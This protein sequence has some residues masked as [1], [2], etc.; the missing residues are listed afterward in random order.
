[1]SKR[2]ILVLTLAFV[3]GMTFAAY[4]EV[5][6]IKVSGDLTFLTVSRQMFGLGGATSKSGDKKSDTEDFLATQARLRVD[7]DLTDNVMATVRLINERNWGYDYESSDSNI[8]VDLAYVTLKEFLYSP[9][10]L[11]VGRQ[12]IKLGNGLI[13]GNSRALRANTKG[14]PSDLSLRKSFDAITAVLNYDPLVVTGLYAKIDGDTRTLDDGVRYVRKETEL[15][16]V[17]ATYDFGRRG[18]KADVY[19]LRKNGDADGTTSSTSHKEDVVNVTGAL[20]SAIPIE[21]LKASAEFAYQYG[22]VSGGTASKKRAY[23]VQAMADY[24]FAKVKYTPALGVSYTYLSGDKSSDD[25]KDKAWDRMFY[26]QALNNITYAIL[27]FS[28]MQVINIKGSVKPKE[29]ITLAANVGLYRL[30]EKGASTL[31][32]VNLDTNGNTYGN[33]SSNNY[34]MD[35]NKKELGTAVDLTATYDYTEDVQFALTGGMFK[36]GRAFAASNRST[37]TQV[38]GSMKVTF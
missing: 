9:L 33:G 12:E 21:N 6:N 37:A 11:T 19:Y 8:D 23:A 31:T 7:A 14:L 2:L 22:E 35:P 13:V 29:D 10:S 3:F 34:T 17:D 24:T 38:V 32:G 18:A 16:G 20:L 28:N 30:A 36:A 26:D 4:A 1:M 15:W 5:Q 25:S 27:P